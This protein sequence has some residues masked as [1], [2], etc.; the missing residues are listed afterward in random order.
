[1]TQPERKT[2]PRSYRVLAEGPVADDVERTLYTDLGIHPGHDAKAA[3]ETAL[4]AHG[5][6]D[7]TKV[8]AAVPTNNWSECDVAPDP[9][10]QFKV[11]PR[12]ETAQV[13]TPVDPPAGVG[14]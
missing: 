8:C 7:D 10:P 11:T 1:M 5:L 2:P 3:I 4:S 9:R 6:P 14:G 12:R 13:A